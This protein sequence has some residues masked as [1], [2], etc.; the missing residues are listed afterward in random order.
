LRHK[1]EEPLRRAKLNAGFGLRKKTVAG[2][3]YNGRN[4]PKAALRSYRCSFNWP[5]VYFANTFSPIK[6]SG[7]EDLGD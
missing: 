7:G 6:L 4:A 2:I 5:T 3:G 1:H